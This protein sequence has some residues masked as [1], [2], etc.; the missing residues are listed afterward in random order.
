MNSPRENKQQSLGYCSCWARC[1]VWP[2]SRA[3]GHAVILQEDG[4][5]AIPH[6]TANVTS[7]PAASERGSIS[8]PIAPA[9]CAY[10]VS[11]N[12]LDSEDEGFLSAVEDEEIDVVMPTQKQVAEA[13]VPVAPALSYNATEAE[14]AAYELLDAAVVT[15]AKVDEICAKAGLDASSVACRLTARRFA[16]AHGGSVSKA[17]ANINENCAWRQAIK[18]TIDGLAS[19]ENPLLFRQG[20]DRLG[21]PVLILNGQQLHATKRS[22]DEVFLLAAAAVEEACGVLEAGDS[23]NAGGARPSWRLQKF[24]MIFFLPNASMPDFRQ[25]GRLLRAFQCQYPE[26]LYKAFIFPVGRM[27]PWLWRMVKRLIDR[28]TASKVILLKGGSAPPDLHQHVA[29]EQL[30]TVFGGTCDIP[31]PS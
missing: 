30:S 11:Q 18:S 26:R 27:T 19:L 12:Q 14:V 31:L 23:L 3:A 25:V 13:T 20:W 28:R 16:I 15:D 29:P 21:H 7:S 10:G 2:C 24:T 6:P 8:V 22:A 4:D 1:V 17:V 5:D 9:A